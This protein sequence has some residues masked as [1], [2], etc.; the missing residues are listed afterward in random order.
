[1]HCRSPRKEFVFPG[2]PL[3]AFRSP[4]ECRSSGSRREREHASV[5]AKPTASLAVFAPSASSWSWAATFPGDTTPGF[6]CL[7]SVSHALEAFIRPAPAGLVSCRSRPW[8]FTLQ[9]RFPLAEPCLL[10]KAD[11]LLRLI[12]RSPLQGLDPCGC[13]CS[14]RSQSS[15]PLGL[16]PP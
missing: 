2:H 14:G 9:G 4:P 7:L 13:P 10:S 3:V 15:D 12:R 11:A 5:S 8:G 6:R 16:L 1:L